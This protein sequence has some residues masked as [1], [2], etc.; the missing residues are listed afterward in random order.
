[1]A[2][3]SRTNNNHELRNQQTEQA[4]SEWNS[5]HHACSCDF[6]III[7]IFISSFIIIWQ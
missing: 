4:C 2:T 7:I 1:M 6:I 5:K 3:F